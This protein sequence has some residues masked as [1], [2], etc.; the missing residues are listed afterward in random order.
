V[1]FPH[2]SYDPVT[3]FLDVTAPQAGVEVQVSSDGKVLWVHVDGLTVLRICRIPDLAINDPGYERQRKV[4][5]THLTFK[6]KAK[7]PRAICPDGDPKCDCQEPALTDA[8]KAKGRSPGY[9]GMSNQEQWD[10]DK[11]LGILD[12]DGK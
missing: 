1:N 3:Q 10:E 6:P 11:R 2:K 7:K 4:R 8:E 5:K 12:W 9:H